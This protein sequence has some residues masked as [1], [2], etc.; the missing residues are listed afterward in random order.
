MLKQGD[1]LFTQIGS[2]GNAI[3]AVTEGY[4]GARVNHVGVA[5]LNRRGIFV[6]EAFPPEVRLTQVDVFLRRSWFATPVHRCIVARLRPEYA[7][8]IPA[9]IRYG[10]TQRD[11]PYDRRYLT[12]EDSLYCSELV[13]DMFRRANQGRDF[14]PEEPMSFRDPATDE[15]LPA[16]REY[17][18]KFGMPVPEGSPGSNPGSI[19]R[20]ARLEII[21]VDGPPT[22]YTP[23]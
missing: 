13:V 21:R 9:A 22:G 3:S 17:Y 5:V 7:P 23:E 10:L 12:D 1:L 11:I 4:R 15:I 6:L 16:W 19:S 18:E 14:F 2:D 8:L 20:D